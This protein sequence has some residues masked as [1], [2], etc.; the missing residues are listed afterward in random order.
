MD[1]FMVVSFLVCYFVLF[2]GHGERRD[3]HARADA[4]KR[5]MMD[6]HMHAKQQE[7]DAKQEEERDKFSKSAIF[8]D[9][10]KRNGQKKNN[11]K[12][13]KSCGTGR[14][15]GRK[16]ISGIHGYLLCDKMW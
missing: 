11:D 9:N 13:Q 12:W 5:A 10:G 6:D 8:A 15:K 7:W 16:K 1:G 14:K 3:F 2:R 4:A